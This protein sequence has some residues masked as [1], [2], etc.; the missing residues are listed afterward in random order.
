MF[1]LVFFYRVRPNVAFLQRNLLKSSF[2][3]VVGFYVEA[4]AVCEIFVEKY[5]E[6]LTY[7]KAI[8]FCV[9]FFAVLRLLQ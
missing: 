8:F 4:K 5:T 6:A 1:P 3:D 9:C 7:E 2:C